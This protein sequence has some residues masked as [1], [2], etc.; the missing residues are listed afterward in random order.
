L[1]L[2]VFGGLRLVPLGFPQFLIVV[3]LVMALA[4]ALQ[5]PTWP[6]L[7]KTMLV[8]GLLSRV[9]V[10]IIMLFAMRGGWGTH[11]DYVG[12]SRPLLLPPWPRFVWLAF[13][14]QLVFWVGFTVLAGSLAGTVV[15]LLTAR[16]AGQD[17]RA[18]R[19]A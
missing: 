19:L 2:L 14:P 15:A 5:W 9:P 17:A 11:Y 10:V 4:A 18:E 12:L 7:A 13:F 16:P 6:A 1:G 3:W 8:Y